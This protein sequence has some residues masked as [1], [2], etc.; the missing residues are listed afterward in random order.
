[1]EKTA[2]GVTIVLTPVAG[3]T[4][5]DL[6]AKVDERIKAA[7]EFVAANIKP[8]TADEGNGGAVGGGKGDH[9]SN[10]SGEGNGQG[11]KVDAKGDAKGDGKG[12]GKGT[13]GGG[14]AGTGGG[15]PDAKTK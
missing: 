12:G 15:T 14:G 7:A 5:A 1:M 11:K 9:G 3:T 4:V 8:A 10:H 6:K 2:K 13:G